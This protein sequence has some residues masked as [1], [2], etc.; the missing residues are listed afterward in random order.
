MG[1][2]YVA[3]R[4]LGAGRTFLG[5]DCYHDP[6]SPCVIHQKINAADRTQSQKNNPI[7]HKLLSDLSRHPQL[8]DFLNTIDSGTHF[9]TISAYILGPNLAT[10]LAQWGALTTADVWQVL[11]A[12]LAI[13]QTIHAQQVIHGD[14]KPENLI[15]RSPAAASSHLQSEDIVLVDFSAA[16]V[17]TASPASLSPQGSPTYAAPEQVQGAT[18][19]S[20]DLYSLGVTC[21]HLLTGIHPFEL[22]D[23]GNDRWGWRNAWVTADPAS[24]DGRDRLAQFLDHLIEPHWQQRCPTVEAAIALMA[25]FRGQKL[26]LPTPIRPSHGLCCRTLSG[27]DGLWANVNAVAIQADCTQA[28]SASDDR[29]IRLWQL[30]TGNSAGILRE[31]ND[32]V[33]AIAYHPTRPMVLASGSRDRTLKLW[34]LRTL[35]ADQTLIGHG[36]S[37]NAL[38]FTPD[39][40]L[41]VSGSADKTVKLWHGETGELLGTLRG[42]RLAVHAIAC[43]PLQAIAV[44]GSAD[45]TVQV[46]DLT[47]QTALQKLTNHTG[48]VRAVAFSPDGQWLA[49]GGEDRRICLWE[50]THWHC[51][52]TLAGHPWDVAALVFTPDG[53]SLISGSWDKTLKQWDLATEQE[54]TQFVAHQD[55]VL[56]VAIAGAILV[57]ASADKTL[58]IWEIPL[59]S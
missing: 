17:A 37:V 13:L 49:T 6:P 57:S 5:R 45:T 58:N 51:V 46:W 18:V 2:R 38:A 32:C 27:H 21:I 39:G 20:S 52:K 42:H 31:H 55:A 9:Y 36:G 33:K 44:S 48:I 40:Q 15:W 29:T 19:F 30:A 35:V 34:N 25:Q 59:D 56:G 11:A 41:L 3:V 4:R 50:T 54:I 24:A 28:S 26:I 23:S 12:I 22:W 53:Q 10:I 8:P 16:T 14:I 47:T 43:S 1:D 7:N